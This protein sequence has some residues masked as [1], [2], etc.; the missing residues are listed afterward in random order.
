MKAWKRK[1][2]IRFGILNGILLC[3][4]I[5]CGLL[6]GYLGG[7]LQAQRAAERWQGEGEMGFCQVSCY[8]PVDEKLELNEIYRFRYAI[9]DKLK[10][11][12]PDS[13]PT[14]TL[15]VD[16]WS[17]TGKLNVASDHGKGEAAAIA[18]GGSFFQFHPLRLLSGSYLT[19]AD[20]MKDR[21]LLDEDLA[22][23]LYGGT[24]LEGMELKVN[25]IPFQVGGVVR[26]EEDSFSRRAYTAG[27]GLYLS[28]DAWKTLNENAGISCYELCLSEPVDGFTVN[29]V[30]EKFPIGQG[31]IVENTGRFGFFRLLGLVGQFG[32]RS[33]QTL[34]VVYPYWENAARSAEDWGA[35]LALFTV[36]LGLCPLISAGIL[37]VRGFK[38]GKEKFSED[39]WPRWRDAMEEAIRKQQRKAWEK[40]HPGEV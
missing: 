20:L 40:R 38:R 5:V 13:D 15:F 37:L 30:R 39:L 35:L 28:W 27:Q 22:W 9:L 33:M 32:K 1:E 7:R 17:G 21:V 24:E 26:R 19:E 23:L 29:F 2:W 11:A 18:V 12:A 31:E 16:A 14:Q 3:L 36:L 10:E 6:S 25:G 4:S 8:L 34:G